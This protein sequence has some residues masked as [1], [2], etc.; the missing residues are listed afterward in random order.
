MDKRPSVKTYCPEYGGVRTLL[1]V[2]IF[3]AATVVAAPAVSGA[4]GTRLA[5]LPLYVLAGAV[6]LAALVREARRQTR[7]NPY[8]FSARTVL[9]AFYEQQRPEPADHLLHL[10]FA[11]IG[12]A[13]AWVGAEPALSRQEGALLIVERLSAGEPLPPIDPANVAWG[14]V[15]LVGVFFATV[16]IDRLLMGGYRELR[17]R[18]AKR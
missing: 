15:L 11:A 5:T 16:G 2:G 10:A 4:A 7:S 17:Y 6:V 14:V 12:T 1:L 8:E 13:A 3:V 9:A 18:L